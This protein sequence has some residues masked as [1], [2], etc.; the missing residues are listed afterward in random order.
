MKLEYAVIFSMLIGLNAGSASADSKVVPNLCIEY[1]GKFVWDELNPE[2]QNIRVR[3]SSIN[4]GSGGKISAKGGGYYNINGKLLYSEV[5]VELD[6]K[7]LRF[8]MWEKSTNDDNFVSDGSHL[9]R[10]SPDFS[11][12][13]ATWTTRKT[14]ETGKLQ[15]KA[16]DSCIN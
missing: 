13:T 1:S 10:I 7:S 6:R 2:I 4:Y 14:G 16:L 5:R 11:T 15:L 9:G 12:V 8:E 3:F